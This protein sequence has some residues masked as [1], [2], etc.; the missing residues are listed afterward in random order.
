MAQ[1]NI[2]LPASSDL[3]HRIQQHAGE[4]GISASSLARA[5]LEVAL[6]PYVQGQL[7]IRQTE[8]EYSARMIAALRGR[9]SGALPA[10]LL[11]QDADSA[12]EV[13]SIEQQP[14]VVAG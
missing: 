1:L 6:E 9:R 8:R 4:L 12:D 5:V 10:R 3:E 11:S 14:A 13:A 7:E 2:H